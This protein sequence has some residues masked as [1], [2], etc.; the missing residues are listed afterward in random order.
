MS[1][2]EL[3]VPARRQLISVNPGDQDQSVLADTDKL[4]QQR[5]LD[6]DK[7]HHKQLWTKDPHGGQYRKVWQFCCI[8]DVSSKTTCDIT[9]PGIQGNKIHLETET[10]SAAYLQVAP[11]K[12]TEVTL[13]TIEPGYEKPKSGPTTN[14]VG[15]Q[16]TWFHFVRVCTVHDGAMNRKWCIAKFKYVCAIHLS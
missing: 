5:L 2:L 13:Q 1:N 8:H 10:L 12:K 6:R 7:H 16:N 15:K 14:F 3:V 11:A 4:R 9:Q